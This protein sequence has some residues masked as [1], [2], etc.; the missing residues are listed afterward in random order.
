L[1]ALVQVEVRWVEEVY[2]YGL[3]GPGE[4]VG[5][6]LAIAAPTLDRVA[7]IIHLHFHQGLDLHGIVALLG[8]GR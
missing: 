1:T 5:D 4:L 6:A 3:L 8:P 7:T 2:H